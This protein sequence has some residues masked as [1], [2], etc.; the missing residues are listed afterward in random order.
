MTNEGRLAPHA[1]P[2]AVQFKDY[3]GSLGEL[4]EGAERATFKSGNLICQL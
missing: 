2:W 4:D 3:V 1:S